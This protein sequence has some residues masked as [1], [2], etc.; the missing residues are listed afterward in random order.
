VF[1]VVSF[2]QI[3]TKTVHAVLLPRIHATLASVISMFFISLESN[4]LLMTGF[5]IM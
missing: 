2:L 3:P 5:S 4:K 1:K